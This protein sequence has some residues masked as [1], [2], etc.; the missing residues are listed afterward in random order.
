MPRTRAC[1]CRHLGHYDNA[2][3][4]R[5]RGFESFYGFYSGGIDYVP[6]TSMEAYDW[7]GDYHN[8][9]ETCYYDFWHNDEPQRD[10]IGWNTTHQTELL[11]AH[12]IDALAEHAAELD[13]PDASYR[14]LLL[15]LAYPNV[16]LFYLSRRHLYP[17]LRRAL[18]PSFLARSRLPRASRLA[19]RPRS[20]LKI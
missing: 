1:A 6:K 10:V 7:D 13:A 18:A 4:P 17:G 3:L 11:N 20:H 8:G 5:A 12:A 9:T 19:S 16:R 2:S 15:Y 14:P